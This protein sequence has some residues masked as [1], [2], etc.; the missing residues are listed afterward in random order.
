[1]STATCPGLLPPPPLPRGCVPA[2]LLRQL[3]KA[4]PPRSTTWTLPQTMGVGYGPF[5]Q[6]CTDPFEK[7]H[8]LPRKSGGE[9]GGYIFSPSLPPRWW[10]TLPLSAGS[11]CWPVSWR[12]S[13]ERACYY[14]VEKHCA[15][16]NRFLIDIRWRNLLVRG[17]ARSV[18]FSNAPGPFFVV[19]KNGPG[20]PSRKYPSRSYG[21]L[22]VTGVLTL[23]V[24]LK[25]FDFRLVLFKNRLGYV[26][27]E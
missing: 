24:G 4:H 22:S 21:V 15:M 1:M 17:R 26:R 11:I 7:C 25:P 13:T 3:S 2:L 18:P 20:G 8:G 16:G 9:A 23:S 27:L 14:G 6:Y 5:L 19:W 10:A 12:F